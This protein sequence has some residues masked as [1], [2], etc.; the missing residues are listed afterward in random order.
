M[1][2]GKLGIL[3]LKDEANDE[4]GALARDFNTMTKRMRDLVESLETSAEEEKVYFDELVAGKT[5]ELR[6]RNEDLRFLL[7]NV[8]QGFVTVDGA[9]S[10]SKERSAVLA[11]WFGPTPQAIQIWD[12]ISRVDPRAGQWLQVGWEPLFDG[13]LPLEMALDQLPAEI[14]FPDGRVIGVEYRPILEDEAV[15]RVIVVLS[16]RTAEVARQRAEAAQSEL[17]RHRGAHRL[18]PDR[19]RGVPRGGHRDPRPDP[20]GRPARVVLPR[21]E[22]PAPHAEGQRGLPSGSSG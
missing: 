1:T 8:G 16:D 3:P 20:R 7:D 9:G 10:L 6:L 18:R 21:D 12:F 5:K 4:V 11:Q 2:Q 19:D 15:K 14:R 17:C 13:S 22:T